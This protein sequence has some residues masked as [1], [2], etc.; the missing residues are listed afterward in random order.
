MLFYR[1]LFIFIISI[2]PFMEVSALDK[3]SAVTASK[4][5]NGPYE[6]NLKLKTSFECS[7][8]FLRFEYIKVNNIP[9]PFDSCIELNGRTCEKNDLTDQVIKIDQVYNKL[10][11]PVISASLS[12]DAQELTA[13]LKNA[14]SYNQN[15]TPPLKIKKEC[16]QASMKR[17]PGNRGY[18]CGYNENESNQEIE[19]GDQLIQKYYGRASG[20]TAQCIDDSMVD[21]M[22]FSV[23]R[24][25]ECLSNIAPID[26]KTVFKIINN[27]TA[28][29]LSVSSRD[30]RG[31]GQITT[32]AAQELTHARK[33]NGKYIFQSIIHNPNPACTPFRHIA[34]RDLEEGPPI[35]NRLKNIC[36]WV[37]P[38]DGL[39]RNLMYTLGYYLT[40]RDH[41]VKKRLSKI[42]PALAENTQLV[43]DLTSIA[44]GREGLTKVKALL[45]QYRVN[46]ES[47]PKTLTASFR[48]E[49]LYLNEISNKMQEMYCP[50]PSAS[51]DRTKLTTDQLEGSECVQ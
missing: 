37:N 2:I 15:T 45:D 26:T 24:A 51:C 35:K 7:F 40:L 50:T 16:I 46:K 13:N 27:E 10:D 33:G 32:P 42:N 30:G 17:L 22:H 39:A 47:D 38:G 4:C 8:D 21:Y 41:Y 34:K 25:I 3:N 48:Q 44:Y 11:Y 23:N 49:S 9:K 20:N 1:F 5:I 12:K 29:N 43:N 31:V 14:S 28:F 6:K 36:A 18:V 19:P